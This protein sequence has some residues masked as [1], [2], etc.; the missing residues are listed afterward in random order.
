[1]PS[2]MAASSYGSSANFPPAKSAALE[3]QLIPTAEG[4]IGS[5]AT[6]SYSAQ[7]S[8]KTRC[9][10]PQ[11]AVRMTAPEKV[12]IGQEQRVKIELR[13]PGT[14]DA[15]GVMLFENVPQNVRHAAGPALEFEIGTL[16]R[17]GA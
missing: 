5:V 17:R 1:M 14:G 16:R 4:E 2:R 13:N 9:T 6:V 7:A 10:M 8:V 12:M 11:L 15:T 3:M